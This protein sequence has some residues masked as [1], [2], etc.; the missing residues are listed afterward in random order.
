[1]VLFKKEDLSEVFERSDGLRVG[2]ELWLAL[3]SS[4]VKPVVLILGV[5][6]G[7]ERIKFNLWEL[8]RY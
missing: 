8:M 1:M 4:G 2:T 7:V 3:S 6:S 5:Y